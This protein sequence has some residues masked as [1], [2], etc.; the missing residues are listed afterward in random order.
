MVDGPFTL[1]GKQLGLNENE[2]NAAIQEYLRN[3]G[4]SLDP[5]VT[6]W[7]AAFVNATLAQSGQ[8]G[9]GSNMARSFMNWGQG[10]DQPQP[11]D[12]A[13]FSRGDPNG[14]FGHVGFFEGYNPDGTIRVLG[15]NQ[16]DA[17]SVSSYSPDRLLGFRRAAD[18]TVSGG[19]GTATVTGQDSPIYSPEDAQRYYDAFTS[20]RMTPEHAAQYEAAVASGTFPLP[21]GVA[22]LDQRQS[23]NLVQVDP[24]AVGRAYQAYVE[25]RMTPEHVPQFEAAVQSGQI[26]LPGGADLSGIVVPTLQGPAANY[27]I[28]D[29][30]PVPI[31]S[32]VGG[33][34][35]P[36]R[37]RMA[38]MSEDAFAGAGAALAGAAG[39][40][41]SPTTARLTGFNE[42][43]G[44]DPT[45]AAGRTVGMVGRT[46]DIGAAAL[47]GLAGVW[48]AGAGAVGDI[49]D[50]FGM[51]P[52]AATALSRDLASMPEAFAG[53]PG[54]MTGP[55]SRPASGPLAARQPSAMALQRQQRAAQ[56]AETVQ[57]GERAG[58]RV[59]TSDVLPPNNAG[60]RNIQTIGERIPIAGTAAPRAA[61]AAERVRAITNVVDE[62]APAG[63]SSETV[64]GNV[65][66]SLLRQRQADLT[67][68]S[69]LKREVIDGLSEGGTPVPVPS[70]VAQL[71]REITRL[72][73]NPT[74]GNT[75]AAAILERYR[76]VVEN[77]TLAQ[78]DDTRAEIG[79]AFSDAGLSQA[80][81]DAGS[82][83][84]RSVYGPLRQDMRNF[85][86]A[87]GDRRDVTR[88]EVANR[89]LAEGAG[90]LQVSALSNALRRGDQ[91]PETVSNLLFS[92][93]PSDVR[94]LYRNLDET[95]R[96]NARAA[97]ILRAAE[98]ATTG[99]NISATRFGNEINK[100]SSQVGIVFSGADRATVQGLSR[101]LDATK[102]AD[103][104][105]VSPPTG[106][107]NM[108]F[109][110]GA[111][112]TDVLGGAGAAVGSAAGI[113]LTARAWESAA[114]RNLLTA[115]G[116]TPK[117]TAA[118]RALID[119]YQR[120]LGAMLSASAVQENTDGVQ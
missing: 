18:G 9:T 113:G 20:G 15:G 56:A 4:V 95:G 45:S 64:I 101:V 44:I 71:D 7:C 67:R 116:K 35:S 31:G 60:T 118:E 32:V 17:V 69:T 86:A 115:I 24:G 29:G 37:S 38:S 106:I 89:R 114:M 102:R 65:S 73:E 10:V 79:V 27:E 50:F 47:G 72:R 92:Q 19:A 96:A 3:G 117:G 43:Q 11:G 42:L 59:M 39:T 41:P 105:N 13:V 110:G 75:E 107:Q 77:K 99:G 100:L 53:S 54:A 83:A 109:I 97:V 1:A 70:V 21:Q 80:T 8:Q 98:K 58:V 84:L 76:G 62:F 2:Q 93:K 16:G 85:I 57:A 55:I 74:P 66:Q 61:Q 26:T 119:R 36:N 63:V 33:S 34:S 30:V 81:K 12:L 25:G 82:R 5:A 68:Y 28:R 108:P 48:N 22:S 111:V 87:N 51:D 104:A 120:E 88:W 103:Q 23:V 14:P 90:E 112:L 91:T 6:A 94:L 40:G 49:A 52:Q 78:L 46:G